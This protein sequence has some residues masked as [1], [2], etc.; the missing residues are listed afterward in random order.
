MRNGG[1]V[2]AARVPSRSAMIGRL[3]AA[4]CALGA[5]VAAVVALSIPS[6]NTSGGLNFNES[7]QFAAWVLLILVFAAGSFALAW[8]TRRR[9]RQQRL[10]V[11]ATVVTVAVAVLC[12]VGS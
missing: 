1:T 8:G 4:V 12:E 5:A 6:F 3:V 9:P 11:T 2:N 7:D 10:G